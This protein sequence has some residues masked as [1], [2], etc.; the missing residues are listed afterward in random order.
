MSGKHW[1]CGSCRRKPQGPGWYQESLHLCTANLPH[2]HSTNLG[3]QFGQNWYRE[4][5]VIKRIVT[6]SI[7]LHL[8]LEKPCQTV[9]HMVRQGRGEDASDVQKR[10][11]GGNCRRHILVRAGE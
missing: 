11:E 9:E 8:G 3:H 2:R 6:S 1:S 10:A 7:G 5:K 4:G